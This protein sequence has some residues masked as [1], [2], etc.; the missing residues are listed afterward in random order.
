MLDLYVE[1]TAD[2]MSNNEQKSVLD[3]N[4]VNSFN[5][6]DDRPENTM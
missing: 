3:K 4:W 6:T 5:L 1:V 2:W